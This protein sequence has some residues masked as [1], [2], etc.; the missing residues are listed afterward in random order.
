MRIRVDDVGAVGVVKDVP[1]YELPAN[2]WSDAK[3][4]RCQDGSVW[5][6]KGYS[7]LWASPPA[8]AP[9]WLFP[10]QT[11]TAYY[12][13]Y[14]GASAVYAVQNQYHFNISRAAGYSASQYL[15]WNG[16][17]LGGVVVLNNGHDVPQF[18]QFPI[19]HG[20]KLQD[21]TAWPS[22]DRAK[23][24]KPFKNFLVA[25]NID[26]SGTQYGTMVKWSH[27]ADIGEVPSSWDIAD[28]TLDAGEY[29]LPHLGGD[30][31]D[32]LVLRDVN[33]LY[34]QDSTWAMQY[35][36][37][38]AIFRFWG[39]FE[40]SGILAQECCVEFY[41]RHFVV[42][43]DDVVVHDGQSVQS[44]ADKRVR[45]YIFSDMDSSNYDK[46]FC[47]HNR[48][49]REIWFCYPQSG[50]TYPDKAAVWNYS[51]SSWAFRDLPGIAH[52]SYGVVDEDAVDT[53]DIATGRWSTYS[54]T[55][56][57]ASA[58]W[59]VD[60]VT[61]DS[62]DKPWNYRTYD[63]QLLN[64]VYADS[65]ATKLW[66]GDNTYLENTATYTASV[67]RTG[68]S[69]VNQSK[70]EFFPRKQVRNIYPHIEGTD[71]GVVNVYVGSQDAVDQT[72]T[73]S[74]AVPY[75]IGQDYRVNVNVDGRLIA[76]KFESRSA[77][78]W[79][80]H[81]YELDIEISGDR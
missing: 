28:P 79:R 70:V 7:N 74:A 53:W 54:G 32:Q 56:A 15:K 8:V 65:D 48:N 29:P 4:I 81:G 73:W 38:P 24:L 41:G 72:V 30:L 31:L 69:L 27:G 57:S 61:W 51:D 20:N 9:Y 14:C 39:L 43:Q 23:S 78:E 76:V 46:A 26:R 16:G 13:L 35:I 10:H 34:R 42:T 58:S 1:P 63:S 3:N 17:N 5:N 37:A 55:W 2:V 40:T 77:I 6:A 66:A 62:D 47:V 64:M 75:T 49:D 25:I 52:A 12:W 18:W 60:D 59:S 80:L 36:G 45:R 67:T 50:S 68:L 71:G 22:T 19:S 33:I 44:V 11:P 21:L